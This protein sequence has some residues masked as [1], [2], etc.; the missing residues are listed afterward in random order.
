MFVLYALVFIK[1][2]HELVYD[3]CIEPI[4]SLPYRR[5]YLKYNTEAL[6]VWNEIAA[7]NVYG[8]QHYIAGPSVT[9]VSFFDRVTSFLADFKLLCLVNCYPANKGWIFC[10]AVI[11]S[12]LSVSLILHVIAICIAVM[13]MYDS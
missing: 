11:L 2:L 4:V 1:W 13:Y 12:F 5:C 7:T 3:E 6:P 8:L 9:M 10:I